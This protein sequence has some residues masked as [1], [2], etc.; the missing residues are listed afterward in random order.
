[1]RLQLLLWLLLTLFAQPAEARMHA[2]Y[3]GHRIVLGATAP[4]DAFTTPSGA[5]GFRKLRTAYSGPAARIRR[6]SDNAELDIGFLGFV[7][8]IGASWNEAAANAHCAATSCFVRTWY[9]QSG[10]TRDLIQATAA[11]QPQVIFACQNSVAC[12]RVTAATQTLASGSVA[13]AAGRTSLSVVGKR[14]SGTGGSMMLRKG[15][16]TFQT[17]GAANVWQVSDYTVGAIQSAATDGV[18]H[19]GIAVIDG[20]AT[21]LRIDAAESAPGTNVPGSAAAGTV[22]LQGVAATVFDEVEAIFWDNYVL[23]SAERVALT[24][25]QRSFW[26]F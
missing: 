8:G 18:W 11:N 17:F 13:W 1:M 24:N 15:V 14:V 7:P 19:A 22:S 5:Y 6:A 9:D 10:N 16:N 20:V 12:L 21:L 3:R 4:L 25:N 26:G 23:T 2:P